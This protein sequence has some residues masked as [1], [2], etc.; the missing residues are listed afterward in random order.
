MNLGIF[1]RSAAAFLLVAATAQ[2]AKANVFQSRRADSTRFTHNVGVNIRP[3]Y[4]LPTHKFFRGENEAGKRLAA[5]GSAHL[6]YSF[7][8]P[9]SS[10]F[11]KL[12]PTAYQG[13]GVA[14]NTFFDRK[15][16]GNPTAIYVFQ[17][18]RL[19]QIS[20][21]LSLDYEWNF[22]ASFG[23]HPYDPYGDFHEYLNEYNLV[24]GSRV[25]AYINFGV[26]LS[27][28]PIRN[29]TFSAGVDLTHF[30]NGNTALPNA[31]VNT[32]G[33]R[34]GATRS[35][36][37]TEQWRRNEA[38][39]ASEYYNLRG[40]KFSQ[41]MTY[42][43]MLYGAGRTKGL[44]W[45]DTPYIAEGTFGIAGLNISPLYRVTKF[46]RA[47][48]SLDIQYDESANVDKHVAGLGEDSGIRFYRPPLSEQLGIGLSV[49]AE[50]VMPVFS[51][52]IGFGRNIIYKGEDL[53]GFYQTLAL[54]TELYKG[55]YLNIG[56][57]LHDFH[58]PNNLMLG[59]GWRFGNR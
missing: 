15:E 38:A 31:G 45:N 53:K 35:F 11:G 24:V 29:W 8:F 21:S 3:K 14:F 1:I 20:Q 57:K 48:A 2:D 16:I 51:V 59:L 30:S 10:H 22:G 6:Q 5:S 42:D 9:E 17:G 39:N 43:V 18:A 28:R 34:F 4:I 36:G 58:D 52:N 33:G 27:W 7:S 49:R 13:I 55:L 23:W 26:L 56:Y 25:N 40:K 19:A 44:I 47:G 37:P 50:F 12:Y 46:F 32:I 54:K 41:R